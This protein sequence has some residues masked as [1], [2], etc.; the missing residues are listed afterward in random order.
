VEVKCLPLPVRVGDVLRFAND[1]AG[2]DSRH[3]VTSRELDANPTGL[4]ALKLQ[5]LVSL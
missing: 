4:M 2:I 1:P 3:V 5:K